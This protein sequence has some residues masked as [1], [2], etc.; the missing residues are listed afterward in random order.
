MID[1]KKPID[2]QRINE[3][4][5][6]GRLDPDRVPDLM[7]DIR[8]LKPG[9]KRSF[10]E[11]IY[12]PETID[13]IT[14]TLKAGAQLPEDDMQ[15]LSYMPS[16]RF[17]AL[18]DTVQ[19]S[20]TKFVN[21]S[22]EVQAAIDNLQA[23]IDDTIT[24]ICQ[25]AGITVDQYHD[26]MLKLDKD[27]EDN[28]DKYN[29]LDLKS[30]LPA[31]RPDIIKAL[32]ILKA[33]Q[34]IASVNTVKP[35][36][37]VF[38]TDKATMNTFQRAADILA[39]NRTVLG[40]EPRNSKSRK[41][42]KQIDTLISLD[43]SNLQSVSISR[44]LSLYDRE[45]H[46]AI[47]TL[48]VEGGNEYI[49]PRMIHQVMRNTQEK[50]STKQITDIN[51]SVTL[52][53]HTRI[54]NDATAEAAAYGFNNFKYDG[55]LVPAERVTAKINGN[56]VTCIH[57]FRTPPLYDYPNRKSQIARINMN[58]LSNPQISITDETLILRGYLLR[59]IT[60]IKSSKNMS[61]IIVY[62][63]VYQDLNII[64]PKSDGAKRKKKAD[65]RKKI[66]ILLDDWTGKNFIISYK[67][68]KKGH[69]FNSISIFY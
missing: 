50:P 56:T 30:G 8:K 12:P 42:K 63:T 18:P 11:S 29:K 46:D 36:K 43:Y 13:Q 1:N 54:V 45:V 69:E 35:N 39:A 24:I 14:A 49:T 7:D 32:R 65:L 10:F 22:D 16:S 21:T 15:L 68:N 38:P 47:I 58:L 55:M 3:A 23:A 66:K 5:A 52:L 9:E 17:A 67:E 31:G 25:E 26:Y 59:R 4:V 6:A 64:M 27:L 33:S 51:N 37:Y 48:A 60:A 53:M 40:M 28:P 57:L 44:Q 20:V 34:N 41:S 62:D 19:E 61:N 2:N